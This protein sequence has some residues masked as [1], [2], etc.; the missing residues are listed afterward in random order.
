M[1]S[2]RC[3]TTFWKCLVLFISID[4]SKAKAPTEIYVEMKM[5]SHFRAGVTA[6]AMKSRCF[7]LV[8]MV[9]NASIGV[10]KTILIILKKKNNNNGQSLDEKMK[11]KN[12]N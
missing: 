9:C 2:T 5:R 3:T 11:K 7:E 8:E 4:R 12:K 1:Y 10:A 6:R